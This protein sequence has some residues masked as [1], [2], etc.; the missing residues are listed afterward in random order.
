MSF[1]SS[2]VLSLVL[3]MGPPLMLIYAIRFVIGACMGVYVSQLPCVIT[4]VS[5][6]DKRGFNFGIGFLVW[7]LGGIL[8]TFTFKY[9]NSQEATNIPYVFLGVVGCVIIHYFLPHSPKQ[10]IEIK[11]F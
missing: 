11:K 2:I 6:F 9:F 7:P 4:E 5:S 1:L 8:P 10:L 3:M